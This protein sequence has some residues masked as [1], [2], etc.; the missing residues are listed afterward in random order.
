M[1]FFV[2]LWRKMIVILAKYTKFAPQ[3]LPYTPK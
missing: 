2:D 3:L 1:D